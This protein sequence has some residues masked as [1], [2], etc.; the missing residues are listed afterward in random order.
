M[1]RAT[2]QR[3]VN[4][5]AAIT[6]E[7]RENVA[8]KAHTTELVTRGIGDLKFGSFVT[9]D[10]AVNINHTLLGDIR[11]VRI[12]ADLQADR[13]QRMAAEMVKMMDQRINT[14]DRFQSGEMDP[15]NINPAML[16]R[17]GLTITRSVV[18]PGASNPVLCMVEV[19]S[20]LSEDGKR[21]YMLELVLPKNT[22]I[23]PELAKEVSKIFGFEGKP[24]V[25]EGRGYVIMQPR[26]MYLFSDQN[27]LISL[28]T[29]PGNT[30]EF[31]DDHG[32]DGFGLAAQKYKISL[33]GRS[34]VIE[35]MIKTSEAEQLAAQVELALNV[36]DVPLVLENAEVITSGGY[37]EY[38]RFKRAATTA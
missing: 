26:E 21:K 22:A 7:S 23:S 8:I 14:F 13:V 15:I 33:S 6:S 19:S 28:L 12:H 3:T 9:H 2:A 32:S 38:F 25:L 16:I 29:V 18:V 5:R 1:T 17:S 34:L 30:V 4:I 24:V 35:G 20:R 27:E 37:R 36:A 31:T 11:L 10:I